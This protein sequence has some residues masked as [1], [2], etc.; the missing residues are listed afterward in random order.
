MFILVSSCYC[1][2]VQI[3]EGVLESFL[4]AHFVHRSLKQGNYVGHTKRYTTELVESPIGFK[5]CVLPIWLFY[6]QLVI[7]TFDIKCW[8]HF[9]GCKIVYHVVNSRKRVSIKVCVLNDGLR[10]V[11]AKCLFV[12][13]QWVFRHNHLCTP[14]RWT[15]LNNTVGEKLRNLL[16]NELLV[17]LAETPG[18]TGDMLAVRKKIWEEGWLVDCSYRDGTDWC[19]VWNNQLR[20]TSPNSMVTLSCSFWKSWPRMM[21]LQRSLRTPRRVHV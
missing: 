3:W 6:W 21:S 15:D 10:I 2:V 8:V 19:W 18:F 9:V 17:I 11:C 13:I 7:S 12:T 5:T 14:R 1:N 20:F 16:L 4:I